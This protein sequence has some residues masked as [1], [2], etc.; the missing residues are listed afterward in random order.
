MKKIK[1]KRLYELIAVIVIL[2]IGIVFFTTVLN[3]SKVQFVSDIVELDLKGEYNPRDFVENIDKIENIEIDDS[4]VKI[5]Q[6]GEYEIIYKYKE[7]EFTLRV[8]VVDRQAPKFEI[9]NVELALGQEVNADLFVSSIEDQTETKTY[10]KETYDFKEIGE[11]KVIV[12]V[13]DASGNKTE[14]EATLKL[15]KDEEKPLLIGLKD[16]SVTKG[17]KIN[18]LSGIS[19]K[20]NLDKKPKIEVDSSQ[21][22]LSEIGQYKVIYTVSDKAGNK[23]TYTQKVTVYEKK[24]TNSVG[25]NGN[26]TVYLTFDDGPSAN[27]AKV[28]EVLKK[29]N[30]KATF[31]VTGNGQKYNYLIKQAHNEG[32]TIGLHTYSH[33]YSRVYSSVNN[34]FNDLDKIGQMVKGQ[35]GFVPKYI[36]F[37]GG[38]SNTVSRKYSKGIMS[39]LT[40]EVQKRGYQY[41][42][43]NCSSGD[44]SGNNVAVS[45]I[46]KSSTSSHANN[47]MILAHDTGAKSTTVQALPQ[48]IEHYKA[49]GY[50]FK[51]IDDSTFTPHQHVN[52]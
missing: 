2:I 31:F 48:I 18:Y 9:S 1:K 39:T 22:N 20:D 27:T 13:E 4:Q 50:T 42:D 14:K 38:A 3:K 37:P 10:F 5:D 51:G 16:F 35:I 33:N 41:Y 7:E 15:I 45:K 17:T 47:I 21:V 30:A 25:Q 32:H 43:W 28:L 49:L 26:K 40:S 29:Y 23:N 36:R 19:A 24:A 46:V 8:K 52:N 11:H 34:Y 44:A 6:L 12:V